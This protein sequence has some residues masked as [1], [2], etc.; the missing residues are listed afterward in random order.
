MSGVDELQRLESI[1][2]D[3]AQQIKISIDRL[4]VSIDITD[5]N[6]IEVLQILQSKLHEKINAT[7]RQIEELRI[8]LQQRNQHQQ[9]LT[10]A[11][12][13]K[14]QQFPADESLVGERCSVCQDEIEVRRRMMRLD[15]DGQHVFCQDCVEGWF[16]DHKTCPSCRHA[17]A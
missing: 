12:I 9:G 11:R 2:L 15:C 14:F 8:M 16:A 13:Q 17:F 3:N 5:H 7:Q 1:F 10:A 6:V 4:Y